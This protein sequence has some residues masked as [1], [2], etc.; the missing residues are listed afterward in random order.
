[1]KPLLFDFLAR[2]TSRKFLL[3]A[4]GAIAVFGV[5]MSNVQITAITA[6]IVAFT[7]AEGVADAVERSSEGS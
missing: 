7:A 3:A 5:P 2:L 1:M 4:V 6:L